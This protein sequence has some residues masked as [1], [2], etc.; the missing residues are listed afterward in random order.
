MPYK[1]KKTG[2]RSERKTRFDSTGAVEVYYV[3]VP[4][5]EEVWEASTYE[6]PTSSY[7]SGSYD[8]GSSPSY[9]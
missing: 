2:T 7:D 9:E 6:A 3:D 8:S 5:Y 4:V 1:K